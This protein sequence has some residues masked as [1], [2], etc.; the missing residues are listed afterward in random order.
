MPIP[1]P[2]PTP[3]P[4]LPLGYDQQTDQWVSEQEGWARNQVRDSHLEALNLMGEYSMFTLLWWAKDYEKGL[5]ALCPT[6]TLSDSVLGRISRA[7]EQP[8]REKCPDCYGT[9]FA[10]GVRAQ[11]VRP[12]LWTDSNT[13]TEHTPRGEVTTDSMVI[14]TTE[15][16]SFR[17]GDYIFRATGDRYQGQEINPAWI[18]SGFDVP[19]TQKSVAGQIDQARLE[20]SKASVA[21]IIP[22]TQDRLSQILRVAPGTHFP[23]DFSDVE[24]INGP[25]VV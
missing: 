6:C 3:G 10:G 1:F 13:D 16:F 14:E 15:D 21:Y 12:A 19:D 9:H 7:Y 8:I 4:Q 23:P 20:D 5:V 11:I 24:V 17:H 18:R 2:S 25:L 22:P